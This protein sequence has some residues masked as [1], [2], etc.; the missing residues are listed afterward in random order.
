M[1][2]RLSS[3][4]CHDYEGMESGWL[5]SLLEEDVKGRFHP[6]PLLARWRLGHITDYP[7]VSMLNHIHTSVC[8]VWGQGGKRGVPRQGTG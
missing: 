2:S 1:P 3:S 5:F 7:I 4:H 8:S 6:T